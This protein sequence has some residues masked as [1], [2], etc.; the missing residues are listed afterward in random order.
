MP[1]LHKLGTLLHKI[2]NKFVLG[3]R[4]QDLTCVD[5]YIDQM[6]GKHPFSYKSRQ[7]KSMEVGGWRLEVGGEGVGGGGWGEQNLKK[8]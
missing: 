5:P 7:Q 8:G 3:L 4:Y 2:Q 6:W 1:D